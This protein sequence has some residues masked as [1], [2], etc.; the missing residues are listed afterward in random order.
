M[1]K[2]FKRLLGL[3]G[4][5]VATIVIV[6]CS[7]TLPAQF[8]IPETS[9]T[10]IP[11]PTREPTT[12]QAPQSTPIPTPTSTP[13][14]T[15]SPRTTTQPHRIN[16]SLENVKGVRILRLWGSH[17]E[18]GYAYGYLCAP[19]LVEVLN[20]M[21]VI[22][23]DKLPKD[24]TYEQMVNS[25]KRY[26]LWSDDYID[27]AKGCCD[28]IEAALGNLPVITHPRIQAGSKKVDQEML[29]VY[30]SISGTGSVFPFPINTAQGCSGFAVWGEATGDG[31]TR[32][33]GNNDA[34]NRNLASRFI[35]VVRK[36]DSGLATVCTNHI[37]RFLGGGV[38]A[39]KGMNEAGV[40][41]VSQG[42][43]TPWANIVEPGYTEVIVRDILEQVKAGP[44]MVT[45]ITQI[46]QKTK[47]N[48]SGT[49][50]F[51]Q[52]RLYS[53]NLQA[54]QMAVVVEKDPAGFTARL[55]SQNMAYKT[56]LQ[57]GIVAT[58]HFLQRAPSSFVPLQN[59]ITRYNEVVKVLA[60]QK[61]SSLLDMQKVLQAASVSNSIT[62]VYM[63]PDS[64]TFSIACGTAE[65]SPSPFL[66]P[67]T[68]TWDEL[69]SP[70]PK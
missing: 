6:S 23:V 24:V 44:S 5:A 50:L 58:N 48:F 13:L 18:M 35:L 70:I 25:V 7:Q 17:Y 64:L 38:G 67:V 54:D 19:E 69:F 46:L 40:A 63:E 39:F 30:H 4:F 36:P 1:I 45:N 2:C 3:F 57:E 26:A 37:G 43:D 22:L 27:E 29:L 65:G 31:Q 68:F 47:S 20:A 52:K 60:N 66:T 14:P 12:I 42:A 41:L 61:T 15:S 33:G 62:S 56:P 28:G 53:E 51:A 8:P 34:P 21:F 32:V 11:A 16:G 49:L 9:P 55:P 10:P 59:S